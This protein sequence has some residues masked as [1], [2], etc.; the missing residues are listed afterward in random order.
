MRE[1][2]AATDCDG[3]DNDTEESREAQR[4]DIAALAAVA[5][6]SPEAARQPS[7]RRLRIGR[8]LCVDTSR[9][10]TR[11]DRIILDTFRVPL[12]AAE[13]HRRTL[14]EPFPSAGS[15][16]SFSEEE[17]PH[18]WLARFHDLSEETADGELPPAADSDD[19]EPEA[20]PPSSK[21]HCASSMPE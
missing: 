17:N 19:S 11:F 3:C 14:S 13:G 9:D 5:D 7:A 18:A 1:T 21:R 10:L 20:E 6:A 15:S 2:N 16:S 4:G 12:A 8:H